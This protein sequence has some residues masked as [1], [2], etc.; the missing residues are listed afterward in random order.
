MVLANRGYDSDPL[1][2]ELARR[3]VQAAIPPKR[4]RRHPC[5]YDTRCY[6]PCRRVERL[7]NRRKQF[8]RIATRYEKLDVHFLAFIHLAASVLY[9]GSETVNTS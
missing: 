8:R 9:S 5:A 6:A 7:I 1:V 4:K 3:G 2:A